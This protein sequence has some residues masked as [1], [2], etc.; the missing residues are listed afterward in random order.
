MSLES[1]YTEFVADV[2]EALASI[3]R[4]LNTPVVDLSN[5]LSKVR[6]ALGN[7]GN[8][9]TATPAPAPPAPEVLAEPAP[10][11]P[12]PEPPVEEPPVAEPTTEPA[13]VDAP[14][15]EAPASSEAAPLA[16][17]TP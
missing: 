13:P 6:A 16:P 7:F 11:E 1:D 9:V 17:A 3:E 12:A 4:K 14:A 10:A 2:N 15:P 5:E 8:T